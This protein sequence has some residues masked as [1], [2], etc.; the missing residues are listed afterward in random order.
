MISSELIRIAIN[1]IASCKSASDLHY[2]TC[3][4]STQDRRS[5]VSRHRMQEGFVTLPLEK[6]FRVLAKKK[7]ALSE[8]CPGYDF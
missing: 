7:S 3:R 6:Q 2:N 5:D 8:T 1:A 4:A